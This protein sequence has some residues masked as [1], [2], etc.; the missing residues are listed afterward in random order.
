ME[1]S[2]DGHH[3]HYQQP[4]Q[5]TGPTIADIMS[6]SDGTQRKL[7]VPQVPTVALQEININNGQSMGEPPN[8]PAINTDSMDERS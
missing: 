6:R 7:P 8:I 3:S 4:Q 5:H 1:P 2:A